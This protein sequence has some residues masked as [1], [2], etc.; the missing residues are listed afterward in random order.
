MT[1]LAYFV[2]L[3]WFQRVDGAGPCPSCVPWHHPSPISILVCEHMIGCGTTRS[4]GRAGPHHHPDGVLA[5]HTSACS[6]WPSWTQETSGFCILHGTDL[7]VPMTGVLLVPVANISCKDQYL[8]FHKWPKQH[9]NFS[10]WHRTNI[11]FLLL[12][13]AK[14]ACSASLLWWSS[15]KE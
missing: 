4:K 12:L 5:S 11:C 13:P 8:T 15:L 14:F 2:C 3:S 9:P 7:L 1:V 10:W 6:R